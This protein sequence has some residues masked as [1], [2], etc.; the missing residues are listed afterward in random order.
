MSN[1]VEGREKSFEKKEEVLEAALN[2]FIEAD[3]EKASLNRIIKNAG[4]SKGTFYYHFENKEALYLFL[5]TESNRMKW[6]FIQS[7]SS[8]APVDF[9][10]MDIFDKFLYQAEQGYTFAKKYPKF[11]Q[12]SVMFSREKGNPIYD[13]ALKALGGDGDALMRQLI[14]AAYENHELDASFDKGFIAQILSYQFMHYDQI[15]NVATDLE[16]NMQN[17]KNYVAFLRYGFGA[18]KAE[19]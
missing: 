10:A 18:K 5:L 13:K 9:A 2:E 6:Q 8:A 4:I 17:L 19:E 11:Y 3:Y 15:F 16:L 1:E 12:L 7:E 14:D